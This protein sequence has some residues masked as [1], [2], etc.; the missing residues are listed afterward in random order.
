MLIRDRWTIGQLI[1]VITSQTEFLKYLGIAD[2]IE[3]P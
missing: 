3:I 2:I 1:G